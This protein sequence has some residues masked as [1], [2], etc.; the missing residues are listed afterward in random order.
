MHQIKLR[1][2][3]CHIPIFCHS[4][5]VSYPDPQVTHCPWWT[6]GSL[7][8]LSNV[9]RQPYSDAQMVILVPKVYDT[10]VKFRHKNIVDAW[11]SLKK[12]IMVNFRKRGVTSL[13]CLFGLSHYD[14]DSVTWNPYA[15]LSDTNEYLVNCGEVSHQGFLPEN[16][17][18][19][20]CYR[21]KKGL[22]SRQL[23]LLDSWALLEIESDGCV[24]V[25]RCHNSTTAQT[26]LVLGMFWLH[27]WTFGRSGDVLPICIYING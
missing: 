22:S 21:C 3:G 12:N 24:V 18:L 2:H 19:T 7:V 26:L 20:G 11:L 23:E 17:L 9:L 25:T 16:M 8:P 13:Y 10:L 15:P 4:P 6:R 14:V 1:F 5:L 27:Y